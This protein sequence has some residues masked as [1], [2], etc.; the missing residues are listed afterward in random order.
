MIHFLSKTNRR[1]LRGIALVRLDFNTEDDWRLRET[2]PTLRFLLG[3]AAKIVIVSHRGRPPILG[4]NNPNALGKFSL[5]PDSVRLQKLLG[6]K[7]IF[8]PH[9]DF[10]KIKKNIDDSPR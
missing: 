2:V 4:S 6:K 5:R 3:K 7:V 10:K 1:L 9:L 8:I